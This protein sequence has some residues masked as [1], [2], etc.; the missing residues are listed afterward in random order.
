MP[1]GRPVCVALSCRGDHAPNILELEDRQSET[2]MV[3]VP[4]QTFRQVSGIEKLLDSHGY[5]NMDRGG[6]P[7]AP[8]HVLDRGASELLEGTLLRGFGA[9]EYGA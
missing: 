8:P 7:P 9:L 1:C 6:G 2:L 4:P 3:V 5:V